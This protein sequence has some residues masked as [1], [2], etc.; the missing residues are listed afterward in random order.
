M[1][2]TQKKIKHL[3]DT[4]NEIVQDYTLY[5]TI[6]KWDPTIESPEKIKFNLTKKYGSL[7]ELVK[8]YSHEVRSFKF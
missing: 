1:T 7:W 5:T 6:V 4:G 8:Q 2:D 3:F